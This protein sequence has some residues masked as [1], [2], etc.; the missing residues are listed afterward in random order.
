M[1]EKKKN[2]ARKKLFGIKSGNVA[3]YLHRFDSDIFQAILTP[4]PFFF[5]HR[6]FFYF[7]ILPFAR[8]CLLFFLLSYLYPPR[9]VLYVAP[10]SF[11]EQ[12]FGIFF[13]PLQTSLLPCCLQWMQEEEAK[14]LYCLTFAYEAF[15]LLLCLLMF[16][17]LV[18]VE[19]FSQ[20]GFTLVILADTLDC[21]CMFRMRNRV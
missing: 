9:N 2:Q 18:I 13:L 11:L 6:F 19:F 8:S 4:A 3:F 21:I 15:C 7:F 14:Q 12:Y 17:P 1:E 5:Y 20:I 10:I 16:C